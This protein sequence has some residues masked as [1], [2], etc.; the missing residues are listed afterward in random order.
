MTDDGYYQGEAMAEYD[1]QE[2]LDAERR[3]PTKAEVRDALRE[4]ALESE[5]EHDR[6]LVERWRARHPEATGSDGTVLAIA[7]MAASVGRAE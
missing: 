6:K 1:R 3:P 2:R 7:Y 5:R 4:L